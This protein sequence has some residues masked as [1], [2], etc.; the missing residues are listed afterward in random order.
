MKFTYRFFPYINDAGSIEYQYNIYK[1][2][3]ETKKF[4]SYERKYLN[5]LGMAVKNSYSNIC[6]PEEALKNAQELFEKNFRW[7]F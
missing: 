6:S 5:I 2:N 3:D 4:G 1:G 7:K